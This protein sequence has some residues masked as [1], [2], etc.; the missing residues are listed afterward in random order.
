MVEQTKPLK[1]QSKDL[2]KK[3]IEAILALIKTL[4]AHK[5]EVNDL[6]AILLAEDHD[7]GISAD[8]IQILLEEA[9]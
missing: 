9:Q 6:Q 1:K 2:A 5:Q 4:E 7:N 3:E 8:E